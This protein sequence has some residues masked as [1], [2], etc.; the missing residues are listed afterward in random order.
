MPEIGSVLFNLTSRNRLP[1]LL[2]GY[3]LLTSWI[4]AGVGK[5]LGI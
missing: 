4:P 5:N 2:L 3:R 1:Y